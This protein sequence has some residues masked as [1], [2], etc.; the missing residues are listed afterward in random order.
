MTKKEIVYIEITPSKGMLLTDG[1]YKTDYVCTPKGEEDIW[2]E[3]EDTDYDVS[4]E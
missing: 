1:N 4:D 2:Y 3:I